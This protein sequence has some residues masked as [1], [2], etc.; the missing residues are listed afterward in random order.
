M[1]LL[2][3]RAFVKAAA[4]G[5]AAALPRSIRGQSGAKRPNILYIMADDHCTR[6][7][8]AYGS[9]INR[10][11]NIDRVAAQGMRLDNC[12]CTNS[13]CS[14]SRAS[15]LTGQYSHINGVYTLDDSLDPRRVTF[16]KLLRQAGYRTAVIGKWHLNSEPAG[17]DYWNVLPG[18]GKYFDPDTTEMGV[19]RQYKGYATD[20]LTDLALDYLKKQSPSTPFCLLLHHKAPHDRFE[21]D[22][23]HAG[24]YPDL[25]PEPPTLYEDLGQRSRAAQMATNKIGQAHTSFPR[26]MA[27]TGTPPALRKPLQYQLFIKRYLRTVAALDD[28]VGRVLDYLDGSGLAEDTIVVYTS[29]QGALIGEHG[30]FDKRFMYDESIR[31]PFLVRYPRAV[32]A[33]ARNGDIGLN[34][35]FAETIL[36]YAGVPIPPDMQGRSLRPLLEGA[37]PKDWRT[38]MYYRYWYHLAHFGIPAHYGVRT[39]DYK[40]IYYYGD[41]CRISGTEPR[42]TTP[43][44]EMFD[45]RNDPLETTNMFWDS[46]LGAT[47]VK[48]RAELRRLRKEFR[49]ESP[50]GNFA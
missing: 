50:C 17:F 7:I 15:I 35:D 11:P 43:E 42:T 40:L 10:T 31:M 5:A 8:S 20:I 26:E 49:D 2:N 14:P 28:N 24:L 3:R 16:P 12:F 18:Q 29:D 47:R 13:I 36:D 38:S 9:R 1:S 48:L 41:P 45:L 6:A 33:G 30:L 46:A 25:V 32:K 21:Y 27:A 4:G 37:T 34:I 22:E 44:W 23:K 19:K 39:R